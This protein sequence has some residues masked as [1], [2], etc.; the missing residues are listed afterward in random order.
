MNIVHGLILDA[1]Y[2]RTKSKNQRNH[3]MTMT[4]EQVVR[5]W[6]ACYSE[7]DI[8]GALQFMS[9]DFGRKGDYTNWAP[10]DRNVW[11]YQQKGFFHGFPN[12]TWTMNSLLASGDTVA[13]EFTERGTFTVPFVITHE[14]TLPP[15]GESFVDQDGIWFQV[16]DGLICEIRAYITNNLERT[17]KFSERLAALME[18]HSET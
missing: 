14:L 4:S 3:E 15:T 11:A 13:C 16:K 18:G 1:K 8:D 9:E 7:K 10:I 6:N 2:P 17:F 5:A 12:W